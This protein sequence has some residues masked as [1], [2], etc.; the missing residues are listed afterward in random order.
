M[1]HL[2]LYDLS[3]SLPPCEREE[4]KA[5]VYLSWHYTACSDRTGCAR[6]IKWA[7]YVWVHEEQVEAFRAQVSSKSYILKENK[8]TV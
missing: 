2:Y 5:P 8:M 1:T 6:L 4:K 3:S 7:K